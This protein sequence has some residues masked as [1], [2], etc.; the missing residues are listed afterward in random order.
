MRKSNQGV[1]AVVDNYVDLIFNFIAVYIAY[2]FSCLIQPPTVSSTDPFVVVLILVLVVISSFIYQAFNLY[3]STMYAK[4]WL[5]YSKI[6]EAN[7]L[8][9]SIIAVLSALFASDESRTF[10]LVWILISFLVST[11][12]WVFKRKFSIRLFRLLNKKQFVLRKVIVV[13]DNTSA[14][15][16]Y[17]RQIADDPASGAMVVGYVGD[18]MSE[19]V[20]CD[21]LGSF[22]ELEKILDKYKPTDVV[23]AIDSYNKRYLIKLVNMCDDRCIRVFF[24]PVIYG[25]FKSEKQIEQVGTM[26]IINI[27]TTPLDNRANA[28]VKRV[29]DIVGSLA[30]IVL[31]APLMLI[32]AIGT[33]LSSPGPVLFKQKRVG[34]MGK[35]FVMFKFRSMRVNDGSNTTWTTNADERKTRFGNF[36]RRTAIDELPQL[37]NVLM[38]SMSLVGPRPELPKFV[39]QFKDTIP[40]YMVKHYVK[41]G[42]TGLAQVKG[43]RGDTSVEDRIQEDIYYIENWSLLMDI[44]ILLKTP[45]K[46]FNKNEKY[47]DREI[48]ESP[49]LFGD[50]VPAP[51]PEMIEI[52][53]ALAIEASPDETKQDEPDGID[54]F[55]GENNAVLDS[56]TCGEEEAEPEQLVIDIAAPGD[57]G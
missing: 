20:G 54:G 2:F 34:K 29:I 38:G 18:K 19:D 33:R 16:E 37:F 48:K 52:Q 5:S 7:L 14:A 13:G 21:K 43:L 45:F 57:D 40:L 28:L 23:F 44:S 11:V 30:L 51:V 46:A 41:P 17:V 24:L 1:Y 15:K 39:N 36:I 50:A 35:T 25:F 53:E 56:A 42:M 27:H 31:T 10:V 32:A 49:E 6:L 55:D 12:L 4:S 8:L 9:F 26:P 3:R 47:L 22:R